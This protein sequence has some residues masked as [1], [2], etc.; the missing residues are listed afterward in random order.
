MSGIERTT[1]RL[2]QVWIHLRVD[3]VSDALPL[4][5]AVDEV[6]DQVVPG[7]ASTNLETDGQG[8]CR[9]R[10]APP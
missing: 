10:W 4:R 2:I 7:C 5:C 3:A 8:V 9:M 1:G 6:E